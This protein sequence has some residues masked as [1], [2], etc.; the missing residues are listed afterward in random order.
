MSTAPVYVLAAAPGSSRDADSWEPRDA[1]KGALARVAFYMAVCYDGAASTVSTTRLTLS[2]APN[3]ATRT[4]GKLS[5]LLDWNRR[6][7]VTEAERRRNQMIYGLYQRNRNPF[8]DDRFLADQVFGGAATPQEA[9]LKTRFTAAELL[10]PALSGDLA[11]P[12]GDGVGNLLKYAF[13]L[14]PRAAGAAALPVGGLTQRGGV[15]YQT[16]THYVNRQ[17]SD[18][19]FRYQRSGDLR[20]WTEAAPTLLDRAHVDADA[21]DVV[22][23]GVPVTT[24]EGQRFLR[25]VVSK[26]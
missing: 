8:V 17:A 24:G 7:A 6:Y 1:D 23:V 25:L 3:V 10:D 20:G 18:L 22:T 5:A 19:S 14:E 4:F 26:P 21:T 11:S 15:T 16:L 12:A 2:D 9:W 13:N